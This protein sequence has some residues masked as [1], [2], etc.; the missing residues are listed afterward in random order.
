MSDAET[1]EL[2]RLN[3][4][5]LDSIA[6]GDWAAYQELCDPSLTSIEPEAPGQVVEGLGFHKFFFDLGGIR[7]RHQTTMAAPHVRVFG[8]VAVLAYVRLVQ[9]LGPDGGMMTAATA[10]TRV[11]HHREGR[12]VHVHFHRSALP[13]W[14]A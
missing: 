1:A 11:W 5:L 13:G 14:S 2:L 6:L 9:R 10:E 7:G 4:R 3:Q 12:W 8:D